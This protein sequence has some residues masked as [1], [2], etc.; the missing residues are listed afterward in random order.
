MALTRASISVASDTGMD[1]MRSLSL[2]PKTVLLTAK[3]VNSSPE[4]SAAM[5]MKMSPSSSMPMGASVSISM[6]EYTPEMYSMTKASSSAVPA[7]EIFRPRLARL[8]EVFASMDERLTF[9]NVHSFFIAFPPPAPG[10]RSP[11]TNRPPRSRCGH[12]E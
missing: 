3:A 9:S 7:P 6:A 8:P 5:P 4:T 2:P 10:T 11:A 12:S 1:S